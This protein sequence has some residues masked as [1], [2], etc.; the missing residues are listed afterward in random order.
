MLNV[1]HE[2]ERYSQCVNASFEFPT[3][4][5]NM[6]PWNILSNEFKQEFISLLAQEVSNDALKSG[7]GVTTEVCGQVLLSDTVK[8]IDGDNDQMEELRARNLE[9]PMNDRGF[10]KFKDG[11]ALLK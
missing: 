7:V 5:R 4:L 3:T 6:P 11:K 9:V 8:I 1:P 10:F 2:D